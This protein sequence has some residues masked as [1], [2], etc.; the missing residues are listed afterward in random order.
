MDERFLGNCFVGRLKY[1]SYQRQGFRIWILSLLR[2]LSDE[3]CFAVFW[4]FKKKKKK[5]GRDQ[6]DRTTTWKIWL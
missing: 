4:N 3:K 5:M 1:N 6:C 2:K